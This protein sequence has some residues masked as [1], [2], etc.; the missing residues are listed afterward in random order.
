MPRTRHQRL[1]CSPGCAVEATLQF[2]DGK[3][4]GVI[5]WHLLAETLRFN[6]LRRLLPS[7]TQRMLTNQLRELEQDGLVARRIV[8][9][10]QE[11]QPLTAGERFG[12]IRFGSRVD[13]FL[14]LGTKVL[15]GVGQTEY[16]RNS[17]RDE[18]DMACEA[19]RNAVDDAGLTMADIDGLEAFTLE[20]TSMPTLVGALGIPIGPDPCPPPTSWKPCPRSNWRMSAVSLA[21][22]S[23]RS[24]RYLRLGVGSRLTW[25][26]V[27]AHSG[28]DTFHWTHKDPLPFG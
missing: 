9:W 14:P 25:S 1:A 11:G 6:Q 26:R 10:V 27:L 5:L 19:I 28:P 8:G 20:R 15:V 3:W 22:Q 12:L 17:G 23:L 7:V 18:L 4:K 13:V 16:T 2:I 24:G 21:S